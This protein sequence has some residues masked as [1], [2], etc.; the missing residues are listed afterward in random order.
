MDSGGDLRDQG[1][2]T[3]YETGA[4]GHQASVVESVSRAV[5]APHQL[6]WDPSGELHNKNGNYCTVLILERG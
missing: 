6:M 4:A 3:P 5:L 1:R 2:G